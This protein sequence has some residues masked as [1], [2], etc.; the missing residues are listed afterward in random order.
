MAKKVWI[1][2][3]VGTMSQSHK[4]TFE[5][6]SLF[7]IKPHI[8]PVDYNLLTNA[9]RDITHLKKHINIGNDFLAQHQHSVNVKKEK[10]IL[11]LRIQGN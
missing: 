11:P 2:Y 1:G 6:I 4:D 5:L 3:N 7:F 8:N 9:S 10:A